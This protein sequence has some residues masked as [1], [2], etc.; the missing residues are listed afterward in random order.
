MIKKKI[1]N[2]LLNL[3]RLFVKKN[4][5]TIVYH[6]FPD[7]ADNSFATFIFVSENLKQYK[8]IWL[9]DNFHLKE[10]FL[11]LISNYTKSENF[12]IL[13]KSSFR[14]FYYY[15]TAEIVFHTHGLYNY[16][17]NIEGQIKINLW[18]GMPLKKIGYFENPKQ[19]NVQISTYHIATSKFYQKILAKAFGVKQ[20]KVKIIGQTRN[21]F[22]FSHKISIH[23][24][25]NDLKSYN[26]TVLW[27]PTFRKSINKDIRID[28]SIEKEKDFFNDDALS[29]LNQFLKG[30]NSICYVKIHPM[31]YRK[32]EDFQLLS[33]IKFIDNSSFD[34]NLINMYSTFSSIDILL[35]DFSSIY[36]DFLL[37]NIPIGFVFSDLDEFKKSRGFIFKDPLKYMPGKIISNVKELELFLRD[38]IILNNDQFVEE[39]LEIKKLFH[40]YD[41]DFS[42]KLFQTIING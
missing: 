38:I 10:N 36:I 15:L 11:K 37:L 12:I 19:K 22:L 32:K 26:K 4:N 31:D 40:K 33:N 41:K 9:I 20:D 5:N 35:T 6:S 2:S 18:H 28:G 7:I 24:L 34:N 8:N 17:G 25:F 23:T 30:N 14:G 3:I 16:L 1:L 27:M 39:R 13:K 29:N 42:K 21:D